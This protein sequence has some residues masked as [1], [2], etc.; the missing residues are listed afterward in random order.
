[1][2]PAKGPVAEPHLKLGSEWKEPLHIAPNFYSYSRREKAHITS[3]VCL[4]PT[5]N[6]DKKTSK[7]DRL[8]SSL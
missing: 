1:M 7:M 5:K 8:S 6:T 4:S 3:Y 2:H